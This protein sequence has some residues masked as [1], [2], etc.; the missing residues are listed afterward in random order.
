MA[1]SRTGVNSPRSLNSRPLLSSISKTGA[2]ATAVDGTT[3]TGTNSAV[4]SGLPFT[5]ISDLN[6]R[7]LAYK[8][9]GLSPLWR[10]KAATVWPLRL[11]SPANFSQLVLLRGNFLAAI[12]Y[13]QKGYGPFY[14]IW[15]V[16]RQMVSPV[17]YVT[18]NMEIRYSEIC[19][20]VPL[21]FFHEN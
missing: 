3:V 20:V 4:P 8:P 11:H 13:L 16:R 7:R 12:I 17:I 5:V 15:G 1:A 10:Q 18:T 2:D 21:H 19:K 14:S 9:D 6:R